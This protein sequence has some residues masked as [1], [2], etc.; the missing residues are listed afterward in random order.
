MLVATGLRL[1]RQKSA[2]G[3]DAGLWNLTG[4]VHDRPSR[5][6]SELVGS[7]AEVD[8]IGSPVIERLMTALAI[9]QADDTTPMLPSGE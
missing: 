9:V 2:L 5:G 8:F 6:R 3:K 1:R 4:L 7:S